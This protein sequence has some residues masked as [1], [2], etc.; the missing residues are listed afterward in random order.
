MVFNTY[1]RD[2]SLTGY[3]FIFTKF[4]DFISSRAVHYPPLKGMWKIAFIDFR[5]IDL[6][7]VR[8]Y[9]EYPFQDIYVFGRKELLLELGVMSEVMEVKPFDDFMQNQIGKLEI[10][11]E[12]KAAKELY[13]RCRDKEERQE[14][15]DTFVREGFLVITL[16]DINEVKPQ[17]DVVYASDVIHSLLSLSL[18]GIPRRG[19]P[20]SKFRWMPLYQILEKHIKI[21]GQTI[22]FYSLRKYL[23]RFSEL[24]LKYLSNTEFTANATQMELIK[25]I[26]VY[27]ILYCNLVFQHGS[28]DSLMACV[29]DCEKRVRL[30]G[31]L[32]KGGL[33]E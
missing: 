21:V 17:Q 16:K 10:E 1:S 32:L 15:L 19:N 23:K 20:L 26:D 33:P 22:S 11:I 3:D 6:E 9:S 5:F 7:K 14:I 30:E 18:N 31:N 2:I 27:T 8:D 28:P 25:R 29:A 24:K 13:S 4:D 12:P